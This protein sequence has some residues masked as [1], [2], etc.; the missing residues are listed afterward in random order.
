MRPL[1][2]P[3]LTKLQMDPEAVQDGRGILLIILLS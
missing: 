3:Y 1:H 2:L